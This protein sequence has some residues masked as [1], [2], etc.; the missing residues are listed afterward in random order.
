MRQSTGNDQREQRRFWGCRGAT[1][2][3]YDVTVLTC[4]YHGRPSLVAARWVLAL[5]VAATLV[6]RPAQAD[7]RD[8]ATVGKITLLNRK[9][10]DAYQ[11][12]EF[13]TALRLLNEALEASERA[14]LMLHPIRARTYMS[15]GIVTLGGF[16]QR[17]QAVKYFRK[18]LQIQP[19]V[20]LSPGLAN[21]DI[22]SAFDE[23]VATLAS[24]TSDEMTPEKALVH[25]PIR[26]A[27]GGQPLLVTVVPDKELGA[28]TIVLR[29]RAGNAPAFTDLPMQKNAAGAF[30]ATIPASATA[31]EQLVYFI[32]ARRQDGSPII[33]RG[34]AVDPIAVALIPA[35]TIDAPVPA[36]VA[37]TPSTATP[38]SFYFAILAGSGIGWARGTGE[39]T[40]NDVKSAGL[41]WAQAA[42]LAPE[43]GYYVTPRLRLGVQGRIQL[44]TGA[45]EYQVPMP[46]P[47]ECGTTE[48]VCS[49]AKAAFAGLLKATWLLVE[50]TSAFQPYVS[51]SAGGGYIRH[52][53]ATKSPMAC[54]PEGD[55]DCKDTVPGGPVLFGPSFGFQYKVA[56]S[57]GL[58]AELQTLIGMS[59]FTANA[60]LNLGIAFQL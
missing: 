5:V 22:Q 32:E 27:P 28:A 17:E 20:R 4:S 3:L 21:P 26:S 44:V 2:P 58:V 18:A 36:A 38:G 33:K 43:I 12:L 19:E 13:D 30:E 15:L 40:L 52:V 34:T 14:G 24:G 57:V 1:Q 49:P 47:T 11:H 59:K 39:T 23:A 54:G 46:G 41:A 9:A 60:D 55:Q 50:P 53:K 7:D 37:A 45:T 16:R 25:E 6:P 48:H 51:F 8:S 31:G 10:V 56:D 35:G 42:Q 29:Y